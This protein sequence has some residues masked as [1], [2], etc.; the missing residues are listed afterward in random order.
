[1]ENINKKINLS[2]YFL[3]NLHSKISSNLQLDTKL[4][5]FETGGW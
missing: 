4:S 5:Y 2:T 1:M 3:L